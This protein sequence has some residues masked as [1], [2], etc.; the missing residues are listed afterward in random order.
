[1]NKQ[2]SIPQWVVYC[3]FLIGAF[4]FAY[5]FSC[6]TS[7]LYEHHPF[8]FYGDS[9]VFQEMGVCILQGGTPYVDLFDHKG[10]VLWFIQA[11]GKMINSQWGI[12]LL[13]SI[14]LFCS[15]FLLYK[16]IFYIVDKST[17]SF[18]ITI[19]GLLF[20]MAFYQRGNLCEEWSLPFIILPIYLYLKRWMNNTS[21]SLYNHYDIIIT[22]FCIGILAMIRL[23]NAA[24][25][26]GFVLWYYITIIKNKEYK[27]FWTDVILMFSGIVLVFILCAAFY[28]IKAGWYG[29][30]EMI[31]GTFI[32]NF[33]YFDVVWE[34]TILVLLKKFSMPLGFLAITIICFF[35]IKTAKGITSPLIVSYILTLFVIG[36]TGFLHYF[37]ILIP[38]FIITIGIINKS[39]AS[40]SYLILGCCCLISIHFG[41]DA[42]DHLIYRLRG[43]K[44]NTEIN[45]GFHRFISSINTDERKSIYNYNVDGYG[46]GMFANENTYQCNRIIHLTH[47]SVSTR[48][49][50]YVKNHGIKEFQP[51]W[52]LTQGPRPEATDEFMQTN[53]TLS[54]SIPGGEFDPIW[55][56]KRNDE[57]YSLEPHE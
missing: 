22:G 15:L 17:P 55:C 25:L 47:L 41:Y 10:P 51:I 42:I 6:T 48:L 14:S 29:V 11:L 46:P 28:L 23:N 37:I 13:Q 52:V 24:P 27:R 19:S 33:I 35:R 5:L 32:F 3:S 40:W 44:A 9:G 34:P 54:D 16:S 39:R 20:L 50:E 49:R 21:A 31:Y 2:P 1:M 26:I 53:Y 7:P 30:Y 18:F 12:L 57:L 43:K 4:F 56:W 36:F 45:D 38:L 8:W